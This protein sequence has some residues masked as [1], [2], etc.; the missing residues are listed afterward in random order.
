M[1]VAGGLDV[2]AALIG[3]VGSISVS[4]TL[5]VSLLV[6]TCARVPTT[7]GVGRGPRGRRRVHVRGMQRR[8]IPVG[9]PQRRCQ[10]LDLRWRHRRHDHMRQRRH[11]GRLQRARHDGPSPTACGPAHAHLPHGGLHLGH[12]VFAV[13]A[14][15]SLGACTEVSRV[16]EYQRL[17]LSPPSAA[18]QC[19]PPRCAVW[20]VASRS[21][22]K[23]VCVDGVY[24]NMFRAALA[25]FHSARRRV[26]LGTPSS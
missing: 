8:A 25:R 16:L 4:L 7:R 10:G 26:T 22:S 15:C 20:W 2:A 3:V 13:L 9:L 23:V 18:P 24:V 21:A 1:F 17:S 19:A 6:P 5:T 14:G 11:P 12:G